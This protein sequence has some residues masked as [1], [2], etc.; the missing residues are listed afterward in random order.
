MAHRLFCET[1][2]RTLPSWELYCDGRESL[3]DG[4]I[5]PYNLTI[6]FS[7]FNKHGKLK[8]LHY[9]LSL[10]NVMCHEVL[11]ILWLEGLDLIMQ[12]CFELITEALHLLL[13][14]LCCFCHMNFN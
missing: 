4:R 10:P 1:K 12:T 9:S 8:S 5:V 11:G 7:F 2:E 6:I 13:N 14:V 3:V